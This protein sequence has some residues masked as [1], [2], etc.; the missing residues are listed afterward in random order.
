MN[1]PIRPA[2]SAVSPL[3]IRMCLAYHCSPAPDSWFI[4]AVWN[5]GASLEARHWMR[6]NG[7]LDSHSKPTA[8]LEAYVF[9]LTHQPLPDVVERFSTKGVTT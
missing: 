2:A 1:I 8:K 7:L 3:K 4:P 6:R 5:S 9:H